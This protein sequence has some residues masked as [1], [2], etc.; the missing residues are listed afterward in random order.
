M[1]T[2]ILTFTIPTIPTIAP[3]IPPISCMREYIYIYRK[4]AAKLC[5]ASKLLM[6]CKS[7]GQKKKGWLAAVQS[8]PM[9]LFITALVFLTKRRKKSRAVHHRHVP[10]WPFKHIFTE[11]WN[12]PHHS[13]SWWQFWHGARGQRSSSSFVYVACPQRCMMRR[14]LLL[15]RQC[16]IVCPIGLIHID[17]KA[18]DLGVCCR[19]VPTLLK[20]SLSL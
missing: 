11:F 12:S 10:C 7:W 15:L 2:Y 6:L 16:S 18:K 4:K 1:K 9:S 13:P 3:T 19:I 20:S 14:P 8:P 5:L 17:S